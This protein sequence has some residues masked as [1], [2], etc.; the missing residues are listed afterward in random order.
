MKEEE[1]YVA[2]GELMKKLLPSLCR[3]K[4]GQVANAKIPKTCIYMC[5]CDGG[6]KILSLSPPSLFYSNLGQQ[7]TKSSGRATSGF[8]QPWLT[9]CNSVTCV[10][11][12][13]EEGPEK[14]I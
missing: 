1:A 14:R 8:S 11:S 5:S 6:E 4:A 3:L 2:I 10:V 12:C 13:V 7:Y 9:A